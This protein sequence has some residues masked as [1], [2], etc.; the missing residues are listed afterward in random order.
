[1]PTRVPFDSGYTALVGTAVYIF[2]Y[3]EW[4]LIYLIQQFEPGFVSRYCRGAPMTSGQVRQKLQAVLDN[5]ATSYNAVSRPEMEA[6]CQK[7]TLLIDKRNALIH[8]HPITDTDGSQILSYQ[9]RV[10]RPLPDMRWP[11]TTV[12]DLIQE[13]DDAACEANSLL[14]RVLAP[15]SP[16]A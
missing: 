4:A 14:H 12:R 8:A 10:D 16:Q 7:F 15:P 11:E 3:Y 1:M 13:F 6:C 9:T 5:T 2:A